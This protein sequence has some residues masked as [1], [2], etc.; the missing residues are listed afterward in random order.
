MKKVLVS[1][2]A[3]EP[4]VGSE[5]GVGWN[6]VLKMAQQYEEVHVVT[7]TGDRQIDKNGKKY[8]RPSKANIEAELAKMDNAGHIHFHYFDLPSKISNLERSTA[9]DMLNVYLWEVLAFFFMLKRFKRKEFDLVQKVTIVSHRFPSFAWFFGKKYIHGPIAGGERYPLKLLSIFTKKN[10]IKELI[11]YFFQMTPLFDPLI[12]FTYM[13]SDEI[14]AVTRESRSILPRPFQKKCIVEQAV[15]ADGFEG[16]EEVHPKK[17]LQKDEPIKLLFVGR[18]L[19]WKGIIL[20]LKALKRLEIPYM[21]NFIGAGPDQPYFEDF[22]K[23]NDLNVNFL[24]FQP[25]TSLP[26]HY[27][28]HDLFVFPSLR[29]S[30]GFVVLEAQANGLPVL[31]LNLGGPYMN[32]DQEKGIVIKVEKQSI[33]SITDQIA[34]GIKT[35]YHQLRSNAPTEVSKQL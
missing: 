9:G 5:P 28:A 15:S 8:V 2:Y 18:I 30:G 19:E 16:E 13:N 7:R 33:L 6:W 23:E 24:G 22:V 4:N 1:A 14:I 17:F 34:K 32:V 3:C 29:D 11:R 12:W 31:T 25:R 20:I 26:D 35:Y 27:Q 21:M 10:R